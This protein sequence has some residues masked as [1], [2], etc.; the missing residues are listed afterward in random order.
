MN[1]GKKA[2]KFADAVRVLLC[3]DGDLREQIRDLQIL[4]EKH[5]GTSI[6]T[7]NKLTQIADHLHPADYTYY[8]F[9]W[10]K[11]DDLG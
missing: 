5:D 2:D 4:L 8:S 3:G 1:M 9:R 7:S 6:G 10:N 11:V